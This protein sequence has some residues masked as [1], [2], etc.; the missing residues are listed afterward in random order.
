M[1]TYDEQVR[2]PLRVPLTRLGPA[3]VVGLVLAGCSSGEVPVVETG[4]VD[5]QTVVE[6]VEAPASVVAAASAV[7]TAPANG[8]VARVVVRDGENVQRGQTLFVVNSPETEQRLAE[9]Q[10][11]AAA[12]AA[13]VE[14]PVASTGASAAQAAAAANRAFAQ[15]RA[16]ARRIQD[17]QLR[18]Q[19][20]QQVAAAEAQ[21]AAAQAQAQ[22]TVDQINSSVSAL[23]QSLASLSQAQQVQVQVAARSAQQAVDALTVKSQIAG[24]VVFGASSSGGGASDTSAL[25]D[26]LPPSLAGQ[27]ESLLGGG[28]SGGG[29]GS[30]TGIVTAGS[31]VSDGDGIL[32]I[33][34][35]SVLTLRAEVD[36][37][38]VLLV[39]RGV[40]ADVELDAVPGARYRAVVRNVDL[41]PTASSRGGVSYVVRLDLGGGTL[42]D[43]K[44]A[45]RPRPG[46]SAVASL[47]VLTSEDVV[48]VPV[49]SV[50]R[51]GD[52]DAV[53]VV[54][55]NVP[56]MRVVTLGAQGEEYLEIVD[57]VTE[58]EMI[59]VRGGDQ[60]V[61]GEELP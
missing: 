38:D 44:P 60:V 48:A 25:V 19:A 1:S 52:Q 59:V 23:E 61:A 46:M 17:R 24:R 3:L 16:A 18:R 8:T 56:E 4:A 58:G 11:A 28:G 40:K 15:A 13:P 14:L 50:F 30:S 55:D 32:T 42:V 47:A 6:L 31:P 9:A 35:T 27:A 21:L 29:S 54:N 51:D 37:T 20:L 5:R 12:G 2:E 22:A 49:A 43:G 33:T 45:P 39:R 57:G 34:D 36:E 26:Q 53:W 41:A 10:Q 7:V